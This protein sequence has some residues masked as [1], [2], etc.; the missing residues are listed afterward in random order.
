M[1]VQQA[2]ATVNHEDSLVSHPLW[3]SILLQIGNVPF[4]IA[5]ERAAEH[6]VQRLRNIVVR[7]FDRPTSVRAVSR[8]NPDEIR[9]DSGLVD[10]LWCMANALYAFQTVY[11]T[12]HQQKDLTQQPLIIDG[13]DP[14]AAGGVL[15]FSAALRLLIKREPVRWDELPML[16]DD[17]ALG[18]KQLTLAAFGFIFFHELGHIIGRHTPIN[19]DASTEDLATS[20]EQ[21]TEADN[22][23]LDHILLGVD[24]RTDQGLHKLGFRSWGVIAAT[25]TMTAREFARNNTAEQVPG[26]K[27]NALERRTH[28]LAYTRLDRLLMTTSVASAEIVKHTMLLAAC[29]PLYIQ[30]V[31][32][33]TASGLATRKFDDFGALYEHLSDLLHEQLRRL[34]DAQS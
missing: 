4:M 10:G 31:Q 1:L 5:P 7:T 29:V 23:A 13:T 6:A 24:A 25:L 15:F 19:E 34:S 2:Y 18:A 8:Q 9:I 26:I 11:E 32:N 14:I 21:E 33:G 12:Q 20:R 27:V 30:A 28:P 22:F 3:D 17:Q 16:G